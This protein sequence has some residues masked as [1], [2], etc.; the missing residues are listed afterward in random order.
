MPLCTLGYSCVLSCFLVCLNTIEYAYVLL[1]IRCVLYSG[2]IKR[3]MKEVTLAAKCCMCRAYKACVAVCLLSVCVTKLVLLCA[4]SVCALSAA[5]RCVRCVV[6]LH[7]QLAVRIERLTV[8]NA[9][10]CNRQLCV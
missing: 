6:L 5:V 4:S 8:S 3:V 10:A 7:V 1:Y 9:W 2:K